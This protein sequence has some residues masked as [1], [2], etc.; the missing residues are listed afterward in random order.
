MAPQIK[1]QRRNES[2][3]G[4][5]K[6]GRDIKRGSP[7]HRRYKDMLVSDRN[8]RLRMGKQI[9]FSFKKSAAGDRQAVSLYEGL[10]FGKVPEAWR[11]PVNREW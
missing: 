9:R 11:V 4:C 1:A 3:K 2:A 6:V 7:S 8:K 5:R 10:G